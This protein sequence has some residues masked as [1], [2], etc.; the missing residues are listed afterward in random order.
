VKEILLCDFWHF[1][2]LDFGFCLL[3]EGFYD[4]ISL[5][6]HRYIS[7]GTVDLVFAEDIVF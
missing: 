6:S 4:I 5:V 1:D 2:D 3:Y 7:N